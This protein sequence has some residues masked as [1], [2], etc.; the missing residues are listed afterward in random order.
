LEKNPL[1]SIIIVNYC[2]KNLLEECLESLKYTD[3]KNYEIII[4]DNNSSDG[5]IEFLNKNY[6]TV[7]V[8]TLNKNYGFAEPNNIGAKVAKGKYLVFLNNDTKVTSNWLDELVKI[9]QYDKTIVMGQ[10]LLLFQDGTVDSSGD[11]VDSL[12]MAYSKH[13]VPEKMRYILS[14]RAACMIVRKDAFLDLGGFDESYFASFEDV[15]LGWKAWLWGFKVMVNPKSIVYH[16]GG[17]TIKQ[18]SKTIEFHSAKNNIML[19]LTNLGAIEGTKTIFLMFYE[20]LRIKL[21]RKKSKFDQRLKITDTKTFFQAITWVIKNSKLIN[22]KR[23][24]ILSRQVRTNDDLKKIG[25]ITK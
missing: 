23:K 17:Q 19:R 13:D 2:G 5:S 16:K 14:P 9:L 12:G 3:Y 22:K 6:P 18:I 8:I 10:S 4:I 15:E 1:V 7:Q 11:F 25:L 24:I 20:I 21:L